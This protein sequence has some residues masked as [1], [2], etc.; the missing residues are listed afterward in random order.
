MSR[1]TLAKGREGSNNDSSPSTDPC[2]KH[3][4]AFI[5]Q[6]SHGSCPR[7][8][9]FVSISPKYTYAVM[10]GF[11]RLIAQRQNAQF[12]VLYAP[13]MHKSDRAL[14]A[15]SCVWRFV[16]GL[17]REDLPRFGCSCFSGSQ[18]ASACTGLVLTPCGLKWAAKAFDH[19]ANIAKVQE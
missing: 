3:D 4:D 5:E 18:P 15:R 17:K 13:R 9:Y 16:F 6:P 2:D 14:Q 10:E 7:Q 1:S 11:E 12:S 8:K 19:E